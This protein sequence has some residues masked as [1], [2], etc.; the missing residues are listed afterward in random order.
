MPPRIGDA[1]RQ[2]VVDRQSIAR[3]ASVLADIIRA[4]FDRP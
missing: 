3:W 1:G 4:V 2:T